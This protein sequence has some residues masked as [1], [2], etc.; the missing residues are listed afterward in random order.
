M[1]IFS[2]FKYTIFQNLSKGTIFFAKLHINRATIF[3]KKISL[4]FV[5]DLFVFYYLC[6]GVAHTPKN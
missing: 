6:I 4:F 2:W 3:Y 1:C 5:E